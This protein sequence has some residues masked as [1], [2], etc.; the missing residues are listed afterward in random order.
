MG[1]G[2]TDPVRTWTLTRP[3]RKGAPAEQRVYEQAELTVDGEFQLVGI[4]NRAAATLRE[5][6]F[7]FERLGDLIPSPA[8]QQPG[9]PE[10]SYNARVLQ[11]SRDWATNIDWL[12]V[13]ELLDKAGEV[14]PPFVSEAAAT[15][16]GVYRVDQFG[17]RSPEWEEEVAFIRSSLHTAE[18]VEML[19]TAAAQNDVERLLAPLGRAWASLTNRPARIGQSLAESLPP[20]TSSSAPATATLATSDDATPGEPSTTT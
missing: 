16:L 6:G 4:V 10:L 17:K 19:E 12:L 3:P 13:A 15:L 20:S 5:T 9:E 14:A 7:P 8:P 11:A 18:F 2:I 1:D